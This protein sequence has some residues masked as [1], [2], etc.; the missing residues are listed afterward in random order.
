MK[1]IFAI[2][3][4]LVMMLSL[5]AC[6]QTD[7]DKLVGT[8]T[9]DLDMSSVTNEML[10]AMGEGA[11]E[12]FTFENFTVTLVMTFNEDGTY[13]TTVDEASVEAAVDSLMATVEDGMVKM[14][15]AQI[16][17]AGL[18][19]TVDEML[20]VSGMTMEDLMASVDTSA[21]VTE[22]TEGSAS[23]G[24]FK[25]EDGKLYM[26][27]GLDYEVDEAVYDTYELDGTTL[28]LT[29]HVGAETDEEQLVAD[30]M[31]PVTLTKAE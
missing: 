8:W 13:S 21:L 4:A 19:M 23:E 7:A 24:K 1:R 14:L 11:E 22:M 6:G 2:A 28:T 3:L 10:A 16:A 27:A 29:G 25:A 31:Y 15:E 9:S 20:A 26:S 30:E 12:Y 17:E 5:A 18:N